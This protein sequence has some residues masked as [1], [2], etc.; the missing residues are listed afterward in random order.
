MT[1]AATAKKLGV[2]FY[3]YVYDRVA[4]IHQV[5]RLADLIAKRAAQLRL[6]ASWNA[7]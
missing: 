6:G 4:G 3:T 1:L 2:S 5:P 7:A